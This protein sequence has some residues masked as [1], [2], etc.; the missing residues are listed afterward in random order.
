MT[1]TATRLR[2]PAKNSG[3]PAGRPQLRITIVSRPLLF[4]SAPTP[5]RFTQLHGEGAFTPS[6]TAEWIDA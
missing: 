5:Q 3:W 6:T 1:T 4:Y 2:L